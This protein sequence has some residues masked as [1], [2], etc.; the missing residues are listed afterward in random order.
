MKHLYLITISIMTILL[1]SGCKESKNKELTLLI[2][3]YTNGSSEGIYTYRFCGDDLSIK[4][5]S[6]GIVDNPSFLTVSPDKRFVYAV[7]ESGKDHSAITAFRFDREIGSLEKINRI[8]SEAGPCYILFDEQNKTVVTANY[9]AGSVSFVPLNSEGGLSETGQIIRYSGLGI[10]SVRQ[11][12][13][14]LHCIAISPDQQMLFATDLGTDRIY[15]YERN[16]STNQGEDAYIESGEDFNGK[17]EPGS[18]PRHLI[19]NKAGS[20]AYLINELSGMVTVF[21]VNA[22][23]DFKPVQ[24]VLADSCYA[25]GSADIHL[26]PD[27]RFLYASTRLEG[28]GIAIFKTN[29]DGRLERIA[30]QP[31]GKHP[32]NF[33]ITPD[34]AYLLVACRDEGMVQVFG[35]DKE[36]GMLRDTGAKIELD[37]PVFVQIIE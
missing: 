32:R 13:P 26:S 28:D 8:K 37:R 22:S 18:G 35:I 15:R 19:F 4:P 30:H 5:L 25:K 11:K 14:H 21:E 16:S 27:E 2:G 33:A 6:K 1:S 31:T 9:Q 20:M 3:T 7:S 17:L 24:S 12:Q 29:P 36:S 23:K 34:G 10:D